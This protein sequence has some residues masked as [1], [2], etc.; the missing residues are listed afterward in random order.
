MSSLATLG[1]SVER[2]F[3]VRDEQALPALIVELEQALLTVKDVVPQVP[4]TASTSESSAVDARSLREQASQLRHALQ[5]G[6]LDDE[7]LAAMAQTT[8]STAYSAALNDIRQALDDFDFDQ[9]LQVLDR[10]LLRLQ[11]EDATAS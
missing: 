8:E 7:V 3:Q 9:A 5:R 6:G 2:A 4:D 1:Q 11:D 10:L